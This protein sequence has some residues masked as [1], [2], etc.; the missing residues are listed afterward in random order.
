MAFISKIVNILLQM[1]KQFKEPYC[2]N[3]L[4]TKSISYSTPA[5][6]QLCHQWLRVYGI[7]WD[8]GQVVQAGSC[9]AVEVFFNTRSTCIYHELMAQT[10]YTTYI[11]LG[12]SHYIGSQVP[13]YWN[14]NYPEGPSKSL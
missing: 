2:S 1:L 6:V 3:T 11:P 12:L 4:K 5:S 8:M 7:Y 13:Y 9:L 14:I 10:S